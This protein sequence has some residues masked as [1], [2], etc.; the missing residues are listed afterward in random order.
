MV[1]GSKGL[2]YNV[3]SAAEQ[4][5]GATLDYDSEGIAGYFGSFQRGDDNRI[6]IRQ[7]N[8]DTGL[9]Q[10]LGNNNTSLLFQGGA[11]SHSATMLQDGNNNMA[12]ISQTSN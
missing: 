12:D 3:Y 2:S 6:G 9:I 10:Q 5:N 1:Q 7:G 8:N 11:P 4:N